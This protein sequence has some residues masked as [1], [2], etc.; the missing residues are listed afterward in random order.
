MI[1]KRWIEVYL[2][3]LLRNRLAVTVVVAIMT[4]FF[5]YEAQ[6]LKVVPQ[7]LDFYPGPSKIS[8]FGH[9]W[10]WRKGHPYINIYNDFRRM[11][12][13]A[14]ILTVILE[15]KHGDIYN[16]TTLQKIDTITKRLVETKG[17]VP[18]QILSI[19][20][21]KMKSIT[22]YGG[23]IQIREVYFP[24]VPQT[25]EDAERVKFAVYS[26]KGIRGLFVAQDDTAALVNAG[27]WEEELDFR[28]LHQ[29]MMD[30]KRDVEDE[31]HTMLIT[32]FPWL[33]TS[34]LRYVPEV[35]EVFV[36]TAAALAFLL[37]NYFRTWT[38]IWV[39]IF[40]GLLSS[41][42][43]LGMGPLLGLNM[44]PLVLVVPIFLTARALSHSVQSM[45]RY[46]EEYHRLGDKHEAIVQSYSH[47]FPPAIASV[48][49]DG[50]GILLVSIAPIPLI[51]KV[52]V[53]SSFWIISI[54]VSVVTLHPIILSVINP[55]GVQ[56]TG[57]PRWSRWLGRA[58]LGVGGV[59][60]AAYSIEIG[61]HLL[62]GAKLGA[63]LAIAAVLFLFHEPIYNFITRITISA[64]AGWRRW[65]VVMLSIA[66]YIL[67]PIW[68]W[69]LKVGDM[70]PGAALLFPQHPYNVAYAKLN[71]KF[72][73]ASQLVVIADTGKEDGMK[74]VEPLTT[75][76][77]FADDMEAVPGAG[78]S[79]TVIDIVKQLARLYHEGEPKWAFVPDKKKYIAELFYTFT[80]TGQA[81][82]LDRFLSPDMRYG[83]VIT[84]F[85][86]YSHDIIMNAIDTGKRWAAEHS[87]EKVKFLFA[88]GLFGVLAAV[89]EAVEDSYWTTLVV[90]M[91]AVAGCLYLTYGSLVAVAILMIPVILSQ[92]AAECFMYL[93]RIDLNV[94]SLPI[95]AAGAGVGVDYG[96]YHFSRMIDAFDEGR[97]LEEA[98]DYATATTGKAIIFTA[99]TMVAGTIFW[100]FSDL[101][102][103][104]EMGLLLALLMVFNTFGGLVIVP[105]WMKII[106]PRFLLKRR[107]AT[108][109]HEPVRL[110]VG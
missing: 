3:F 91:I 65:A 96:I 48:L 8:L 51:Q 100:W 13:S 53:F 7:F 10:T 25:Q 103:Q 4:A 44:D 97:N 98:V 64:S 24:G 73:G 46:H 75:M 19:A 22:T 33:Y 17:V 20:H 105:A 16:P 11:F 60:F 82:D 70:T 21:P 28:Y 43:A 39:P 1:P 37:W 2:W 109:E 76:E 67:C 61:Y 74:D 81:G 47:L 108:G 78:A 99:T 57:Y 107:A 42:W 52:A 71:E 12:G 38:G 9:E 79:V 84:L 41:V 54:I 59:V 49:S 85:H 27:F 89:N 31:N 29:R 106:R 34:I 86:G 50:I 36:I 23:A 55:P 63:M 87:G 90:V 104:A 83:T 30:L 26:T 102:F 88:G 110:A 68:G 14:N 94:N 93:W 58:I 45:D 101:K 6:F 69:R 5:A 80:Q 92:L 18:Y 77:E 66:L 32:G 15:V 56:D 35:S 40:S 62:G 72:L 95:A